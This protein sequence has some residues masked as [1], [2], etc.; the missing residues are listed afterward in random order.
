MRKNNDEEIVVVK[1][2]KKTVSEA[3]KEKIKA[4][5]IEMKNVYEK[6]KKVLDER[7]EL[8]D[9]MYEI[10]RDGYEDIEYFDGD[11]VDEYNTLEEFEKETEEFDEIASKMAACWL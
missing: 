10:E 11:I 5:T 8:L 6:V 4:L 7:T 9:R 3:D 1:R 2:T